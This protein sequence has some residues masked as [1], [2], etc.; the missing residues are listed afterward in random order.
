MKTIKDP[1]LLKIG[2][3]YEAPR[4]SAGWVLPKNA[5]SVS[6]PSKSILLY[7]GEAKCK[8]YK[9]RFLFDKQEVRADAHSITVWSLTELNC[10]ET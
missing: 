3:L 8:C 9:Y 6:I 7:L 1:A 10:S 5:T 4:F 2:N